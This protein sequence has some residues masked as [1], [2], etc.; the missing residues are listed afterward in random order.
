MWQ[1]KDYTECRR[2]YLLNNIVICERSTL[3]IYHSTALLVDQLPHILQARIAA[4]TKNFNEHKRKQEL[5]KRMKNISD[6]LP[7]GDKWLY[8]E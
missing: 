4:I 1:V 5:S 7:I 8:T 6:F 2:L 3:L